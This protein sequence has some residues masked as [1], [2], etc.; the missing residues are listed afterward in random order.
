M[1]RSQCRP[2][3]AQLRAALINWLLE[4]GKV[5][6]GARLGPIANVFNTGKT[7]FKLAL[8]LLFGS[9]FSLLRWSLFQPSPPPPP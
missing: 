4:R 6:L 3:G 1:M 8:L 5:T 7:V 2:E 9:F